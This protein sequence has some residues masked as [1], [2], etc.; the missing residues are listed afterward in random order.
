[1]ALDEKFCDE[2]SSAIHKVIKLEVGRIEER[3]NGMDHAIKVKASE[4]DKRFSAMVAVITIILILI[5]IG[6]RFLGK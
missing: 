6:L 4:M 5:E 1:M 3:L 2:R